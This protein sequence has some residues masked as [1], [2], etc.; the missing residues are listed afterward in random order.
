MRIGV[1]AALLTA[2][3]AGQE[4][5]SLHTQDGGHVCA[6]EYG[7]GSRGVVLGNALR[8]GLVR[9]RSE[10]HG[11]EEQADSAVISRGER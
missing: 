6:D 10:R 2:L 8:D 9:R 7:K 11:G 4:S 5:I 1:L 3:A